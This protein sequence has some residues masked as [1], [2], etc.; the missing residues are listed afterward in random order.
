[1]RPRESGDLTYPA[2]RPALPG[3]TL[4]AVTSVAL[5]ATVDALS[6]SMRQVDFGEVLLL[7]DRQ[8][9]NS[10]GRIRWR[11]IERIASRADYSRFLLRELAHHITTS[12]ALCIQWDGFVLNGNAWDERFLDFDYIGAVW[13]QFHD[14]FNVGNGGF[15]LRS[16]RLLEKC[17]DLPFDGSEAEDL[18]IC[19][20]YRERL[21]EHG[22]RFAPEVVANRFAYERTLRKGGEFGFHGALNLVRNLPSAEALRLFRSLESKMLTKNE[23]LEI[24]RWALTHGRARLALTMLGRLL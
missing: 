16:R 2:T 18:V 11:A 13:P 17:K 8:P 14:D 24:F 15:S 7:S 5:P 9:S 12:H 22:L 1:M 19:R 3:V 10:L 23:R 4:V 21:E 6:A 20:R